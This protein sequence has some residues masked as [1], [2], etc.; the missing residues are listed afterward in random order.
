MR[1]ASYP[2]RSSSI[3]WRSESP[4]TTVQSGYLL[5]G[6]PRTIPQA[7]AMRERE[8][9]IDAVVEIA[10]PDE[11]IIERMS[12]R[13]ATSRLRKNV[14]RA[15]QSPGAGRNRRRRP[16][17]PWCRGTMTGRPPCDTG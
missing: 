16:E 13:R 4:P 14:P 8:I 9:R 2:T 1:G 5:D 17:N 15:V 3:W 11:D 10:V 7:E 6:F 12:G